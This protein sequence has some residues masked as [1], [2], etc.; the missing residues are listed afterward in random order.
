[1]AQCGFRQKRCRPLFHQA[2]LISKRSLSDSAS[3]Y[4][5]ILAMPKFSSCYD[6]RKGLDWFSLFSFLT[7]LSE[8]CIPAYIVCFLFSLLATT[9]QIS[10]YQLIS[11]FSFSLSQSH[12][13]SAYISCFLFSL[14]QPFTHI[15]CLEPLVSIHLRMRRC[16]L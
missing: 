8:P 3:P 16:R 10:L 2:I 11:L 12:I 14:S 5:C 7:D 13:K 9:Y 15:Q 6:D 1:M 4:V